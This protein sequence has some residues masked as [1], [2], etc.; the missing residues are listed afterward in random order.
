MQKLPKPEVLLLSVLV[1]S[2]LA[3]LL[4]MNFIGGLAYVPLDSLPLV[5]WVLLFLLPAIPLTHAL[6]RTLP[7]ME[8]G[9]ASRMSLGITLLTGGLQFFMGSFNG[10]V[11]PTWGGTTALF[12]AVGCLSFASA[13]IVYRRSRVLR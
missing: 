7:P 2:D 13:Y 5:Y 3:A 9:T 1:I 4:Y 10:L 6:V 8:T 11:Q 12:F